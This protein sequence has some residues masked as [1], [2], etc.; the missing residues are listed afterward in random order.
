MENEEKIADLFYRRI[1]NNFEA[2]TTILDNFIFEEEYISLDDEE[3]FKQRKDYNTLLKLKPENKGNLNMD[4]K[5]TFKKIYIGLDKN[6]LKINYLEKYQDFILN[7]SLLASNFTCDLLNF[8]YLLI[9]NFLI[10]YR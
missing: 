8:S 7:N 9:L 1:T 3:Y 4:S 2:L 5:R 10:N 6:L